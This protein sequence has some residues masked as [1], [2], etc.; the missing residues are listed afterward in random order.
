M[1][2]SAWQS[3]PSAANIP[4]YSY[5]SDSYGPSSRPRGRL[6][7]SPT[8]CAPVC[9]FSKCGRF[10]SR[11]RVG[12]APNLAV[13]GSLEPTVLSDWEGPGRQ[14][15]DGHTFSRGALRSHAP[16]RLRRS[17]R[18]I[19]EFPTTS[20]QGLQA[21]AGGL[22][23]FLVQLIVYTGSK[24]IQAPSRQFKANRPVECRIRLAFYDP[25]ESSMSLG[26]GFARVRAKGGLLSRV[27]GEVLGT[28]PKSDNLT[29]RGHC[30]SPLLYCQQRH[31]LS[32]QFRVWP[33]AGASL[34]RAV[35]GVRA[36]RQRKQ[37]GLLLPTGAV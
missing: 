11:A 35:S 10:V 24:P 18:P 32:L 31:A 8:S 37:L 6:R 36:P 34:L 14:G 5:F 2:A 28:L 20:R 22:D 13:P 23:E 17:R 33:P 25:I 30:D 26:T 3:G 4:K 7:N 9:F 21:G 16:R 19:P 27:I 15:C 29:T 1:H 12:H